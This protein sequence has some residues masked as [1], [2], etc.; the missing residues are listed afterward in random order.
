MPRDVETRW[1]IVE[2]KAEEDGIPISPDVALFLAEQIASNVRELEGSLLRLGAHA[3]LSRRAITPEYAR[4][5]LHIVLRAK[6]RALTFEDIATAVCH[7]Y[8]VRQIDLRS[9]RR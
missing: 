3:S 2:K 4:E 8:S 6:P 7:H 1:A 5:V 9:R